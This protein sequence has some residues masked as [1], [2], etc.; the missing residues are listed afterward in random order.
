MISPNIILIWAGTNATIPSGYTRE[1]SLDSKYLKGNADGVNPGLTGGASTHTHTSPNHT[2]TMN[3]HTHTGSTTTDPHEDGTPEPYTDSNGSDLHN[4]G[5]H[6]T[7]STGSVY[8]SSISNE[9]VTYSAF[10]N[11][12]P[13]HEVIFI[14]CS[15]YRLI[16][17]DAVVLFTDTSAPSGFSLCDGG[18]T[19]P[20]LRNKYL[21]GAG[22]GA[23]SGGTGGSTTNTHTIAHDHDTS[24]QHQA[25]SS[26]PNTYSTLGQ[27]GALGPLNASNNHT[28]TVTVN[29]STD[30][31]ASNSSIGSQAETVEPA[32]TKLA[33]IQNTSGSNKVPVK[34]MVA[35]W[36]GLLADIPV[37]W[38]ICDGTDNTVNMLG[39]YLK[40]SNDL[41]EAGDTGGANTH[42]HAAES[43]TH[44][45]SSHVHTGGTVAASSNYTA[46][47]GR[48]GSLHKYFTNESATPHTVSGSTS[49]VSATLAASNTTANSSSNEPP[50][51]TVAF[52]EFFFSAGGAALL[53]LA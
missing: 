52:I 6:H 34:K 49:S 3:S 41:T 36:D 50:Y 27:K 39:K 11:D 29:A 17:D 25:T 31:N 40:C 13:Y 44:T 43:H 38:Q 7:F 30:N 8:N 2:H 22:T 5:H 14:K 53:T 19:T 42:T 4:G 24:H 46:N 21:K 26:V 48:G 18:G 35:I 37:G 47:K 16:P 9:A 20:D 1:T 23:D 12:P 33:A 15:G 10:S 32:Y 28:H 51:K 45:L